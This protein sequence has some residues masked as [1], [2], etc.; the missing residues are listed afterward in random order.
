MSGGSTGSDSGTSREVKL[1]STIGA[2][3]LLQVGH[4]S[5]SGWLRRKTQR[6]TQRLSIGAISW[7][8]FFCCISEGCMYHFD[9]TTSKNPKTAFALTGY[10]RVSRVE[11]QQRPHCFEIQPPLGNNSMKTY[12]FSCE[13]EAD[14]L[15]WMRSIY[16]ALLVANHQEAPNKTVLTKSGYPEVEKS[17]LTEVPNSGYCNLEELKETKTKQPKKPAVDR[18]NPWGPMFSKSASKEMSDGQKSREQKKK[19]AEQSEDPIYVNEDER[20]MYVNENIN[21]EGK[22]VEDAEEEIDEEEQEIEEEEEDYLFESSDGNAARALLKDKVIQT[23]LV[24]DSREQGRKIL[25]VKRKS[26]Y[27][28][29]I[30][31]IHGDIF[32]IEAAAQFKSLHELIEYY[33]Q[34]ELCGSC[35]GK[36]YKFYEQ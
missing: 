17:V 25:V 3:D 8:T 33:K 29:H 15:D 24:R 27:K 26:E 20:R 12:M 10:N 1:L 13:K 22:E 32:S 19:P 14:M 2:K 30:I 31:S 9:S 36:G 6:G 11:N 35:I 28:Q 18:Y 4:I 34:N 5:K 23:F 7:R 21:A 16:H